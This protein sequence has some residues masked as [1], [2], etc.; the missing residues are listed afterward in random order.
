MASTL[1]EREHQ[2]ERVEPLAAAAGLGQHPG[3]ERQTAS[4]PIGTFSQ[5]IH[6]QSRPSTT[7]PPTT[8]PTATPRPLMPPQIPIAAL[9][10]PSRYRA[11]EQGQRQRHHRGR[12]DSLHRAGADEHPRLGG[13]RAGGR[14]EREQGD[15]E[16]EDPAPAEPVTD[17]GGGEQQRREGQRVGVDEPLQVGQRGAELGLDHRQRGGH[18]QVVQRDHEHRDADRGQHGAQRAADGGF[19]G[20][21]RLAGARAVV[22]IASSLLLSTDNKRRYA[23]TDNMSSDRREDPDDEDQ[24]DRG[25]AQRGSPAGGRHGVRRLRVRG[26]QDRRDRPAGRRLPAVRDPAVRHQAATVPGH[27][28]TASATGSRRPSAAPPSGSRPWP[29]WARRTTN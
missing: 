22:V 8:G 25:R 5:K 24:T 19:P 7:A 15:A 2:A 12:A 11:R 9:R 28:P 27:R 16:Q 1:A 14:R 26:H 17:R 29:A 21:R 23:L 18:D 13:Q 6:C 10:M 3:R 20:R 4:T